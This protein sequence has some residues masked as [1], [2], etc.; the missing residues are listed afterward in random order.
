MSALLALW[1]SIQN[2]ERRAAAGTQCC[3]HTESASE[4][5]RTA[6]SKRE[7]SVRE[8]PAKAIPEEETPSEETVAGAAMA[9]ADNRTR[10]RRLVLWAVTVSCVVAGCLWLAGTYDART[11]VAGSLDE[12]LWRNFSTHVRHSVKAF[13][14]K[15]PHNVLLVL[16]A[17]HA[18]QVLFCFPLLH[19]TRMMYGYFFDAWHGGLICCSWEICIVIIFV[20]VATQNTPVRKPAPELAGFLMC[21]GALRSRGILMPFM[22]A[23]HMSSVPLVTS[24]CLVLFKV[25]TRWEFLLSHGLSTILMTFKD[26]WLGHFLATSDGNAQN[27]AITA[28]LLSFSALLQTVLTVCLMGFVTSKKVTAKTST[29]SVT[30]AQLVC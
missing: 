16:C 14:S 4:M 22:V 6:L 25:A 8:I 10:L 30:I 21:V 11:Y 29:T 27:I 28:M 24:T 20:I 15:Y 2:K 5:T 18:L 1:V 9:T 26:T 12:H 17:V 3:E 13:D 23:L 19:V 7:T